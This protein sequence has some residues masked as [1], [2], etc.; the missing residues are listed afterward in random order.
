MR[1]KVVVLHDTAPVCIDHAFALFPRADAVLPVILIGKTAARP[2][3]HRDAE[4]AQSLQ[5]IVPDTAGI[6]DR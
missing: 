5:N 3:K 2:A 1:A 6:R 4:V